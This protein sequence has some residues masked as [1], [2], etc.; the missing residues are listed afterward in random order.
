L[1]SIPQQNQLPARKP[2]AK[3]EDRKLAKHPVFPIPSTVILH[4]GG[5]TENE[6]H[7][8][9]GPM[10]EWQK[11]KRVPPVLLM[12]GPSGIG[13]RT[14]GYF[15]AQW[16]LCKNSG[17]DEETESSMGLFGN[18]GNEAAESTPDEIPTHHEPRGPRGP[19]G[20]CL[21]CIRALK[22]HWVDFL[23]ITPADEDSETLKI[24]QFRELKSKAGFGAH[25]GAYRVILI[26]NADHMTIQAANSMLKLLE[27]PPA[28]WLF[29]L[30]ASD[31]S[32]LLP[33]I[34]SRCQTVRLKPFSSK[35]LCEL[36]MSDGIPAERARICSELGQ[37][38]WM[39]SW[40][41]A[42]DESWERRK[43]LFDFLRDPS[44]MLNPILD[45]AAPSAHLFHFLV[46][47]LELLTFDLLRWSIA[48]DASHYSW[49]NS[50][51]AAVLA[52]HAR[53]MVKA[54]GSMENARCFWMARAER[55]AQARQESTSPLNRKILLQD[56]LL[57]WIEV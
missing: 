45:W 39:S 36:L 43:T 33:T 38:S 30:T 16:I 51:A 42:Q 35:E 26:P 9:F 12:T 27:E 53:E 15:L 7:G 4:H 6:S 5:Q 13:K 41:L 57:P 52:N 44:G 19:C 37:G 3:R 11:Q 25:E 31:P 8:I 40:V 1:I 54:K 47:Q 17:F 18:P 55:L 21:N 24:D 49:L 22:G 2:A 50:D 20:T 48:P 32:L 29:I 10:R 46:N 14:L 23:E 34:V 56:L 28:S